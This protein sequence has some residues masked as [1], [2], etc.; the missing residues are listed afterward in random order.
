[1]KQMHRIL[2]AALASAALSTALPA[3]AADYSQW[4]YSDNGSANRTPSVGTSATWNDLFHWEVFTALAQTTV[5][6]NPGTILFIR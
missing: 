5:C 4:I 3:A 1:M 6:H 2:A